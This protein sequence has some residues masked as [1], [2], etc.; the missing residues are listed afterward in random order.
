MRRPGQIW[1]KPHLISRPLKLRKTTERDVVDIEAVIVEYSGLDGDH[2]HAIL[3]ITTINQNDP[4]VQNDLN[5][6][7]DDKERV[8][9]AIRFGDHLG[10]PNPIP[11]LAKNV[12][13]HL[14]GEWIP[15]DKAYNHGGEK[16]LSSTLLTT[17]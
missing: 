13:L 9:L 10:L 4:D 8:F 6:V 5:R 7:L 3:N 17:R 16:C 12:I 1:K 2:Q 14:K 11:D 15:R